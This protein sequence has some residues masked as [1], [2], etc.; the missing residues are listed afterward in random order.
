MKE[1]FIIEFHGE[2]YQ[3]PSNLEIAEA[4]NKLLK[5]K[6]TA[7]GSKAWATCDRVGALH[8]KAFEFAQAI[9]DATT[10][11]V[12]DRQYEREREE[13]RDRLYD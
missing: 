13:R 3:T 10:S 11:L 2:S 7:K 1:C 4:L 9:I 8:E 5:K 12:E 6:N